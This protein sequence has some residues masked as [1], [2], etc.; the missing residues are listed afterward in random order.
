MGNIEMYRLVAEGI[1]ESSIPAIMYVNCNIQRTKW[2]FKRVNRESTD[3]TKVNVLGNIDKTRNMSAD[4]EQ[5]PRC[6][7]KG[8]AD[9]Y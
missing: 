2:R 4:V 6:Y 9:H 1:S 8:H 5:N 7:S 3:V